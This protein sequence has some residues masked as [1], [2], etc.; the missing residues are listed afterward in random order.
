MTGQRMPTWYSAQPPEP[1]PGMDPYLEHPKLWAAFQHQTLA[2]LYQILLP[3]LVDRYRARVGVREYTAQTPLFTSML[4]E[5]HRE[6]YLE[7]CARPDGRD[8]PNA[9]TQPRRAKDV[10]RESGAESARRRWLE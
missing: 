3:G 7:I 1:F 10:N 2:C 4:T 6:E 9:R 8:A 5:D